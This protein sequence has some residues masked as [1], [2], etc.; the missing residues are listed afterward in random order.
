MSDA[1]CSQ[2]YRSNLLALLGPRYSGT[3]A[4]LAKHLGVGNYNVTRMVAPRA[5]LPPPQV[6]VEIAKFFQLRP[7]EMFEPELATRVEQGA[8]QLR[9]EVI[10]KIA[11]LDTDAANVYLPVILRVLRRDIPRARAV[12]VAERQYEAQSFRRH[13]AANLKASI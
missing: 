7:S 3:R 12:S 13:Q 8:Q 5:A 2:V 1:D 6:Q 9:Q 4:R 10:E 11:L